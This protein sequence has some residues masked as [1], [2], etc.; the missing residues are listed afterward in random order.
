MQGLLTRLLLAAVLLAGPLAAQEQPEVL[1]VDQAVKIALANNRNLKIVSLNLDVHNEKLAADK[2]KR[3][4]SFSTYVFGS[5]LLTPISYTVPAGQFG[6]LS[7]DWPDS[8][9]DVV[10]H[11]AGPS[12]GAGDGQRVAAAVVTVPDQPFRAGTG[13]LDRTGQGTTCAASGRRWSITFDR[14]I[15]RSCRSKTRSTPCRPASSST[16]SWTASRCNTSRNRW[17]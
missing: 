16:R 4:P 11:D 1:T 12:H 9:Y 2:T 13:T 10:H 5:Q 7:R 15:T 8:G 3:L 14:T 17:R 6:D